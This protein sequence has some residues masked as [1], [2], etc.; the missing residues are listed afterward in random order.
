M[1]TRR[2]KKQILLL[3]ALLLLGIVVIIGIVLGVVLSNSDDNQESAPLI[4]NRDPIGLEDYLRGRMSAR[5]FNGSWIS[6]DTCY[7]FDI[8][9]SVA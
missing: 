7:Y 4:D 9:V 3:A 5:R 6:D 1:G 8:I 2:K